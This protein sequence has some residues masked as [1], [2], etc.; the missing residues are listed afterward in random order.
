M[1]DAGYDLSDRIH[2]SAFV[3]FYRARHGA[4]STT[5]VDDAYLSTKIVLVNAAKSGGHF[6]LALSPTLEV[7]NS[8][9][10]TGDRVHWA[11]PVSAEVRATQ[12]LR[13]YTAGGYFSRGA[14]FGGIAAEFTAPTASVVWVS[15]TDSYA[16]ETGT[17]FTLATSDRHLTNLALGL[18][19]LINE[20]L[21]VYVNIGRT[22]S[23]TSSGTPTIGVGGGISIRLSRA[24]A[25]P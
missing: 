21:A 17:D 13:I 16:L 20:R 15:L 23:D 19:Q 22:I 14:A 9:F 4:E 7:L 25:V 1:I 12:R 3:P 6:G 10:T 8:D 2:V 18:T 11:L 24:R 5:G